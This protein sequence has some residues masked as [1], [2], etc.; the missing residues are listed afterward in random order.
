MFSRIEAYKDCA[1][2]T[3][4]AWEL[5]EKP[6]LDYAFG[7]F[8][9]TKYN[10]YPEQETI[11]TTFGFRVARDFEVLDLGTGTG[12][13]PERL[14]EY[15]IPAGNITG[16]DHNRSLLED[17]HFPEGAIKILGDVREL[18]RLLEHGKS[19]D[20]ITA[21][22]LFHLLSYQDYVAC[23]K[24]VRNHTK[25]YRNMMLIVVPHPLRKETETIDGYHSRSAITEEAP[26]KEEIQ[27]QPKTIQDYKRG[28]FDSGFNTFYIAT[29]GVGLDEVDS[30]YL[31]SDE[32]SWM[33]IGNGKS[34]D[35]RPSRLRLWLLA[36]PR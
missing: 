20:F 36:H 21:N 7:R 24:Q 5:V 2:Q 19:F 14:T 27:V 31:I 26:W 25:L 30:R 32:A 13:V 33:A 29:Y 6:I 1:H 28:L 35:E 11:R 18:D 22:M 4:N 23:L 16:I 10:G 34:T 12:R 8:F 3:G 17:E 9:R 15:G